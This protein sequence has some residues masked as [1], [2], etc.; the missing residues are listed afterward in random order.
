M[1]WSQG[2][3]SAGRTHLCHSSCWKGKKKF[4]LTNKSFWIINLLCLIEIKGTSI[5]GVGPYKA[6]AFLNYFFWVIEMFFGQLQHNGTPPLDVSILA[7]RYLVE[8]TLCY[9]CVCVPYNFT[10]CSLW[11]LVSTSYSSKVGKMRSGGKLWTARDFATHWKIFWRIA[12]ILNNAKNKV[13]NQ[14]SYVIL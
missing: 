12:N 14:C 6:N 9:L 7:K 4:C 11:Y 5:H 10:D 13:T 3:Y 1:H 2:L 8:H